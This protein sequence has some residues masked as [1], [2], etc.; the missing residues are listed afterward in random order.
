[1]HAAAHTCLEER[2]K[3][4]GAWT[5]TVYF[6]FPQ[7]SVNVYIN[8]LHVITSDNLLIVGKRIEK[9]VFRGVM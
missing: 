4:I 6:S 1:M 2:K 3:R 9:S 5:T 7:R 8:S